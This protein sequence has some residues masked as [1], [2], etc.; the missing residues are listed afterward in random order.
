MICMKNHPASLAIITD[1]KTKHEDFACSRQQFTEDKLFLNFAITY[2]SYRCYST[3]FI[4]IS[5]D[6]EA[7]FDMSSM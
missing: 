3:T 2:K 5:L 1:M 6:K 7:L 4:D